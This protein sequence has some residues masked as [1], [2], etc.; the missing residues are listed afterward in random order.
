M[1]SG[2][3]TPDICRYPSQTS[4]LQMDGNGAWL[5][6]AE[7]RSMRAPTVELFDLET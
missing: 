3:G 2:Q 1:V 7:N 6:L 5:P 4:I